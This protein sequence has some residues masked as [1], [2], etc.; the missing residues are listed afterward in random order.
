[1]R[2]VLA[3]LLARHRRRSALALG[4]SV[5]AAATE[6]IGLLALVPLLALAGIAPQSADGIAGWIAA[7]LPV[8]LGLYGALALFLAVLAL[9]Q[10]VVYQ[11]RLCATRARLEFTHGLR[12]D[13][14]SALVNAQWRHFSLGAVH[15][16]IHVLTL[17]SQRAGNAVQQGFML[18]AIG[19]VI[20]VHA[21]IAVSL[22]L[23]YTALVAA[24]ALLL[25]ALIR[26]PLAKTRELGSELVAA[27][28][29]MYSLASNLL[30]MLRTAKM[31]GT[32]QR[33]KARFLATADD[34]N[35]AVQ[36]HT[37]ASTAA[38]T[39]LQLA[40][41]IVL[42][43]SV[44]VATQWLA[45][46]PVSLIVLV[47][48]FGRLTPLLAQGLEIGQQISH[49]L[50]AVDAALDAIGEWRPRAE[51]TAVTPAAA[52]DRPRGSIALRD[53][54]AG[55][56]GE[57]G[58]GV[59][60]AVSLEMRVGTTTLVQ[61]PTG[62]GKS[63]LADV[64]AGL[65][66]PARGAIELDGAPLA[67]PE[68]LA[69]RAHVGY[70]EQSAA[71]FTGTIRENLSW[72]A[73]DIDPEWLARV[74]HAALVDAIVDERPEGLDAPVGEAGAM[75][76]GGQRQRIAIAR[77]LVR[78]PALLVL[79]EVTSG[80]DE[81][82]ETELLE[83]IRRLDPALTVLLISHRASTAAHAEQVIALE[84]GRVVDTAPRVRAQV[85]TVS[86]ASA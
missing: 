57:H 17:E 21:A 47:L 24:F 64:V 38:T 55:Y 51:T 22:S 75:L 5:A 44:V 71:L 67:T 32:E 33:F 77:E 45:L 13:L 1:M 7:Q 60:E 63:T 62:A 65:L 12:G 25:L 10:L 66:P 79:D 34:F 23:A 72:G 29:R 81:A 39:A 35:A 37:A 46:E 52:V 31:A 3:R 82:S 19:A 54:S 83:R 30:P 26:W 80:L 58:E 11:R 42:A 85:G 40:A 50:G 9:R 6:G 41:G 49:E 73:D 86:E 84:Q 78:A 59:L 4:L 27:N 61:G 36:R 69:W 28:E 48:I 43:S 8:D 74:T 20:A 76:S 15:R 14:L 56:A 53:V 2:R 16:Q 68:R 18:A 70:V